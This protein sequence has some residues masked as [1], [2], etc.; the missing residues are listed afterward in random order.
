MIIHVLDRQFNTLTAM[1]NSLPGAIHFFNDNFH[2]FLESVSTLELSVTKSNPDIQYLIVGNYLQFNYQGNDYLMTIRVVDETDFQID[3]EAESLTFDLL[4]ESVGEYSATAPRSIEAYLNDI[5]VDSDVVIGLNEVR[6]STRTLSWEGD[7]TV[8]ERLKSIVNYFGAEFEI[9]TELNNDRS[10]KQLTLNIYKEYSESGSNHGVGADRTDITLEVGKNVSS[11]RKKVDA[12]EIFTSIKPTGNDGL[13]ISS[14]EEYL[15]DS[16]RN[17]QFYT[18]KGSPRIYAP[19][20]NSLYGRKNAEQ[21]GYI[22]NSAYTFDTDDVKTLYGNA[23]SQLKKYCEPATTYE[24]EGYYELNIGDTVSIND[25]NFSPPLL[26]EARVAEME[27]SFTDPAQNKTVFSNYVA[28]DSA[29]SSDLLKQL[30]ALKNKVGTVV[31]DVAVIEITANTAKE[32]ADSAKDTA[33]SA[34][35]NANQAKDTANT[36]NNTANNAANQAAAANKKVSEFEKTLNDTKDAVGALETDFAD[37]QQAL[38]EAVNKANEIEINVSGVLADVA[39]I[40]NDIENINADVSTINSTVSSISSKANEAYSKAQAVEGKTVTLEKS[41][42]GLTGRL[43]AVETTS[44]STT[45]KLNELEVTV[46]GQ[47]QTLATV[48]TAANSALSKANVLETTVDGVKTTITSVQEDILNSDYSNIIPNSK[49][50]STKGYVVWGGGNFSTDGT[51][52]AV[53]KGTSTTTYGIQT[54]YLVANVEK[55]MTYTLQLDVGSYYYTSVLDYCFLIYD[56]GQ[57]NQ[58]LPDIPVFSG[59]ASFYTRSITFKPVRSGKVRVLLAV[60]LAATSAS[61]GFRI[62]NLMMFKG[63]SSIRAWQPA[64]SDMATLSKVNQ[65][66]ATVDGVKTTVSSV[67]TTA[68]SALSKATTTETTVNGLKTTISSVETTANSALTKANTAQSTADGNKATISSVKTTADSALSKATQTET[69]VN[70][71]KTTVTSVQTTANNALTKATQVET[72]ANGI[73]QTVT[74]VQTDL[75]KKKTNRDFKT[76]NTAASDSKK[77]TKFARTRLTRQ[78]QD[79][80]AGL[81]IIYN[82]DGGALP[83]PATIYIR[84]KQ[85]DAMGQPTLVEIALT[86][87]SEIKAEDLAAVITSSTTTESVVEYYIRNNVGYSIINF[88]PFN[89]VSPE[90]I[91]YYASQPFITTLP[92]GKQATIFGKERGNL[93]GVTGVSSQ[94]T[95]L[96]DQINLKVSKGDLISQINVEAGKTLI[97]TGKLYLDAATVTFSGQAFIPVASI[98]DLTA[99]AIKVGTLTGMTINGGKITGAEILSEF[100][101]QVAT[102]STV[103]R[104]GKL[105]MSGGYFRNDFQTYAKSTGEIQ[106]N[107]FSQFSNE[108]MQFVVF[109]G[110]QTTKADRFLSINPYSFTM[111]DSRGYGGNLTFQDLY[112]VEQTGLPAASGFTQ[113]NSNSD[114]GNFPCARRMGRLVQLA[115]AFKN[116]NAINSTAD[117]IKIGT[118]P[119]WA[120]PNQ[121]VNVIAQGSVM[122]KFLLQINVNGDILMSRYGTGASYGQ[123]GA[124]SWLNIACTYSAADV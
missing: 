44:T 121:I 42:D 1:D 49:G 113:Y 122:N 27:V 15:Y 38:Q 94:I 9:I 56:D 85:Q 29:I 112:N 88:S 97:Q 37:Q 95:Q 106:N 48:Q 65:V 79:A 92:T 17:L 41:V 70:G 35:N 123:I 39:S 32:T 118:V 117:P 66:E 8:L 61:T 89:E 51:Q 93:A 57:G 13:T 6:S 68:D 82:G 18:K 100:D 78:Y 23:L 104:K 7:A 46:D 21:G 77:W 80:A 98:K 14:I 24:V 40:N 19:M 4:N 25:F 72:T 26:L 107:G 10:L 96:S 2:I 87:T 109:S 12:T 108:A 59:S 114:S 76:S 115:G 33:T 22:D 103:W 111:T 74:E 110:S 45:K 36:A 116:S 50:D 43:T 28:F 16:N 73:R 67:K 5:L 63:E 54:D 120:R 124:G 58:K 99:D 69:T 71:L 119:V 11:V 101:Y 31:S 75:T 3:I 47:K 52:I 90:C 53:T 20:A 30:E 83:K 60:N 102:G 81:D 34:N 91:T 105:S 64:Y 55:D 62:K 86:E 84:H